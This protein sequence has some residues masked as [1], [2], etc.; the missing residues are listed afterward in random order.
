[1]KY[2][3][4]EDIILDAVNDDQIKDLYEKMAAIINSSAITKWAV[5]ATC[6]II[7]GDVLKTTER[8]DDIYNVLIRN[9]KE[10]VNKD[11]DK[12]S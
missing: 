1:M 12:Q 6:T 7:I 4:L 11:N 5:M 8:P 3:E 10:A 2:Q 9:L